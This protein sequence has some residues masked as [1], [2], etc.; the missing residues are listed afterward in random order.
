M[1]SGRRYIFKAFV[2]LALLL[3]LAVLALPWK[4]M[5]GQEIA[6]ILEAYGFKDVHVTVSGA[7]LSHL[8]LKDIRMRKDALEISTASADVTGNPDETYRKWNGRW[9]V[10]D[11]HIQG[12]NFPVPVMQGAGT[13]QL[14]P[15]NV[16]FQ[17]R[18]K[19]A[20]EKY[21]AEFTL[22]YAVKSP[23][24]STLAITRAVMPWNGGKLSLHN[25]KLPL[26]RGQD[27]TFKVEVNQISVN[28]LIQLLTGSRA[29]AT[30]VVSGALP[31]TVTK[32]GAILLG[33]G[34]LQAENPGTISMQPDAIPGDNQQVALL[35][36]VLKDFHYTTL[37]I[38]IS[39]DKSD[40]LSVLMSL[41]GM[42]PQVYSGRQV[43]L[44]VHLSGDLVN[45]VQQNI[46]PFTNPEKFLK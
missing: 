14:Q 37:T 30:G 4:N 44:N 45:L 21:N 7:G 20:D 25:T 29:S 17:G 6:S 32:D 18:V 15:D 19:N 33:E 34:N 28:V 1:K 26:V 2:F 23:E 13:L 9:E 12:T 43:K 10:S 22:S 41:S 3:V 27:S 31:V 40:K 42:N 36:D 35:R 24:K 5:I 8:S 16:L 38:H 39:G 46:A 11:I